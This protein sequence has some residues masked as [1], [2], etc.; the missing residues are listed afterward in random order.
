[1]PFRTVVK[2]GVVIKQDSSFNLFLHIA[3]ASRLSSRSAG[4]AL[5]LLSELLRLTTLGGTD[6]DKLRLRI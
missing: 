3:R 1:M 2:E 6:M 5:R 4:L